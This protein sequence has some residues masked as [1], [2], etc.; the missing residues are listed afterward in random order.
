[1]NNPYSLFSLQD[2]LRQ[3]RSLEGAKQFFQALGYPA[4]PPLPLNL[5]LPPGIQDFI[6]SIHQIAKLGK[7][8]S[9]NIYHV[10]IKSEH[11]RQDG[12]IPR[13]YI[14]RFLETFYRHY[15]QGE[16]L[17]VFS[18]PDNYDFLTFISPRRLID[19][20]DPRKV[21]LWLRIL[22]VNRQNPYRTDLETLEKIHAQGMDDPE[23]LSKKHEEAFSVQRV[24]EQFFKD[25]STAFDQIV[26]YLTKTHQENDTAWAQHY[27]HLLLNRIMFLYFIARKGWLQGKDGKPE[28]NFMKAFWEAYKNS[29][30][31][32]QFH[33]EWLSLLFFEVLNRDWKSIAKYKK[34]FP[35]WLIDAFTMAPHL[36]GG[37]YKKRKDLDG[38]LKSY[39][40]DRYFSLLFDQWIDGAYPGLFERYNFTVIESERFDEEVAVD[41]EMLG[42]VYERLVNVTFQETVQDLRSTAG[43]FI[44]LEQKLTSCAV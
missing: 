14:R 12:L 8:T 29:N 30:N 35:Q 24:T 17:F 5:D 25:Y 10:E 20:R 37:L 41:P 22:Q 32:D 19:H 2:T 36:N 43:I 40:P 34:F 4:I 11:L 42:M 26:A 7:K 38:Q 33:Q 44:P 21:R 13:R 1:M 27:A 23:I 6:A 18:T 15:P 9:F 31:K 39:L 3:Y 28:R 16:N